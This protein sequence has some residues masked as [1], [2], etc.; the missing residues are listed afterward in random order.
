VL[1]ACAMFPLATEEAR[2]AQLPRFA[3]S[4]RPPEPVA[5]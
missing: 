5:T 2:T 1:L 3:S 4:Q